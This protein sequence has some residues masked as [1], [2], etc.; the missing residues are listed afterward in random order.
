[1]ENQRA[2]TI[3]EI[4]FCRSFRLKHPMIYTDGAF[5][6]QQGRVKDLDALRQE[7]YAE[8]TPMLRS[9][10]S[11]KVEAILSAFKLE[12][13]GEDLPLDEVRVHPANGTYHILDGFNENMRFC[14]HRLPVRFNENAPEPVTWLKFLEELLEPEDILTLQEF[15][16][17]CLIPTNIGQKMLIITGRGG[18]GKSRIGIVMRALLGDNMLTGSLSKIEN[19]PFARADLEHKLLLV[20]DDLKMEALNQASTIK[21]LVT[22]EQPIDLERKGLQSYQGQVYCRFM[23]FGNDTLRTLHD[24]SHGFFRRQIILTAKPIPPDRV[25]DPYLG[26]RLVNEKEGIFL[27]ALDGF[28]RLYVNDFRFTQSESARRSLQEAIH[29]SVN[30]EEFLTSTGYIRLDPAASASS[31]SLYGVYK[32][33]CEDNAATALSVRSFTQYLKQNGPSQGIH[34]TNHV[35]IGNEKQARGFLGLRVLPRM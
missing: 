13:A 8:L 4:A 34:Y 27:W 33:W 19:N 31:R 11:R 29:E 12:C 15:M 25:D 16:G 24:R 35:P 28:T 7:I 3:D 9:G 5:F 22:A 26:K 30:L 21:T 1:M 23:A 18:E 6:S 2:P 17:Y 10:V 14:R 32:D 20:D